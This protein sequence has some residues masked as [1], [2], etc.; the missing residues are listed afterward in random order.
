MGARGIHRRQ[1]Y[2]S[3]R[4]YVQ[5]APVPESSRSRAAAAALTYSTSSGLDAP[6]GLSLLHTYNI[7]TTPNHNIFSF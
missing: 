3:S 5:V 4:V 1:P 2:C 7:F 6:S